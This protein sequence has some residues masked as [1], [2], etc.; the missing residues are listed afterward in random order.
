MSKNEL[1]YLE[2]EKYLIESI[3]RR[4]FK[5]RLVRYI[6]IIFFSLLF[7]KFSASL[8]ANHITVRDVQCVQNTPP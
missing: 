3:K 2:A 6:L 1:L 8:N 7:I 5:K 4:E